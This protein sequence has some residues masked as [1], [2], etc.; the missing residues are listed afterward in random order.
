[1][2]PG[3]AC[4]PESEC[5]QNDQ[6]PVSK[7]NIYEKVN[8]PAANY[9]KDTINYISLTWTACARFGVVTPWFT[10]APADTAEN[11]GVSFAP[12]VKITLCQLRIILK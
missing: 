8:G 1:M 6:S 9:S 12:E 11:T 4:E 3:F 10:V 2:T 7:V 5:I